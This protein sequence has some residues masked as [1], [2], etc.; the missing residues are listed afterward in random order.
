MEN[1]D[2]LAA[3]N[4]PEIGRYHFDGKSLIFYRD[5]RL[6]NIWLKIQPI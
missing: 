5:S 6:I 4:I 2:F 1:D 3:L